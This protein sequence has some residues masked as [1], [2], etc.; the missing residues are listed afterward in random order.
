MWGFC[1]YTKAMAIQ[2]AFR[3]AQCLNAPRD[4]RLGAYFEKYA[5][6]R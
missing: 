1:F 2:A 4:W 5:R 6:E 3:Q